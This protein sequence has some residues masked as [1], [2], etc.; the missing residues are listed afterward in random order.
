MSDNGGLSL[1]GGQNPLFP[2]ISLGGGSLTPPLQVPAQPITP[3]GQPLTLNLDPATAP[4]Q[5]PFVPSSLTLQDPYG[6]EPHAADEAVEG[7]QASPPF[8]ETPAAPADAATASAPSAAPPAAAAQDTRFQTID[9]WKE[10]LTLLG[11]SFEDISTDEKL[12]AFLAS[13]ELSMS[14]IED[15]ISWEEAQKLGSTMTRAYYDILSTGGRRTEGD[16]KV[17]M[18]DLVRFNEKVIEKLSAGT[19]Q[20]AEILESYMQTAKFKMIDSHRA[21]QL[22]AEKFGANST[23]FSGE[24]INVK[25]LIG[26]YT[27]TELQDLACVV[28]S[29]ILGQSVTKD[30]IDAALTLTKEQ[31]E[32]YFI[33]MYFLGKID[34]PTEILES[35]QGRP[36]LEGDTPEHLLA[37]LTKGTSNAVAEPPASTSAS[38]TSATGETADGFPAEWPADLRDGLKL[39]AL[40]DAQGNINYKPN[41]TL[42][43]WQR[44]KEYF[45]R[46][47][48][49][50]A[51]E[52]YKN[53]AAESWQ[54]CVEALSRAARTG[55][56][57]A[58]VITSAEGALT[59]VSTALGASKI[60]ELR[61]LWMGLA[62][63]LNDEDLA[64]AQV[65]ALEV[66]YDD[67]NNGLTAVT[68]PGELAKLAGS[69]ASL[70]NIEHRKYALTLVG[71][72][73]TMAPQSFIIQGP[74]AAE[75]QQPSS[76][77]IPTE[78]FVKQIEQTVNDHPLLREAR[79][80]MQELFARAQ[81]MPAQNG[82]PAI[83][84]QAPTAAQ[85][86]AVAEAYQKAIEAVS[87]DTDPISVQDLAEAR[88]WKAYMQM[89]AAEVAA[90][91]AGGTEKAKLTAQA[92]ALLTVFPEV[93]G[94]DP[95]SN[96]AAAGDPGSL[97][98]A[99]RTIDEQLDNRTD[100]SP[101]ERSNLENL[102][103]TGVQVLLGIAQVL[104]SAKAKVSQP[105]KGQCIAAYKAIAQLMKD[106]LVDELG[107][108]LLAF[109]DRNLTQLI[110]LIR[111][112]G[113][114]PSGAGL[115]QLFNNVFGGQQAGGQ[116]GPS[117]GSHGGGAAA[118]GAVQTI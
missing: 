34:N 85:I 61:Q 68:I 55:A 51:E 111:S 10:A 54:R 49:G 30:N 86:N 20:R 16:G 56:D 39:I 1:Y 67:P 106:V 96:F 13:K 102:R 78:D 93:L 70:Q 103:K 2:P 90:A 101:D 65:N 52:K 25:A 29:N 44:A 9:D 64:F 99:I 75:G 18:A 115:Q 27:N 82:Q 15:G 69:C 38:E 42:A 60:I 71:K 98:A 72:I 32:I 87:G 53:I 116:S 105:L 94:L 109:G 6:G 97:I 114:M 17:E 45:E 35:A 31:L 57:L 104:I 92:N 28:L 112:G 76:Q 88:I 89:T 83:P 58:G 108:G 110:P 12:Q 3:Q 33:T 11:I 91:S 59:A 7:E 81:G 118:G 19:G 43:N 36:K 40:R 62:Q 4:I 22:F 74:A 117:G 14:D 50:S 73:K 84:P 107:L 48:S 26:S 21:V 79:Q 95:N 41:V 5:P 8:S 77:S 24:T 63:A 46:V 100:L 37:W 47:L 113:A 66:L 23:L 80:K